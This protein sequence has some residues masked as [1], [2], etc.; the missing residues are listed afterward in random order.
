MASQISALARKRKSDLRQLKSY[1]RKVDAAQEKM[2]REIS[3]LI[4][5]KRMMPE[6][7][8]YQ[9]LSQMAGVVDQ[10]LSAF[11]NAIYSMGVTWTTL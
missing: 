5:R 3:R 10:A 7:S 8:D 4:N 11:A 1:S 9:R 2:E 6:L